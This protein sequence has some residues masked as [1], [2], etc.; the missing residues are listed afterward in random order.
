MY[1]RPSLIEHKFV[2]WQRDLQSWQP[3]DACR[4]LLDCGKMTCCRNTDQ[5]CAFNCNKKGE[6]ENCSDNDWCGSNLKCCNSKCIRSNTDCQSQGKEIGIG[7]ARSS[8]FVDRVECALEPV[9][10]VCS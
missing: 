4:R 6:N 5:K 3:G 7:C 9:E 1:Q 2:H 10:L 8:K